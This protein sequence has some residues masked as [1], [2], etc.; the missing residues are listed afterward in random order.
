MYERKV[1]LKQ[2]L[3]ILYRHLDTPLSTRE[4]AAAFVRFYP[5]NRPGDRPGAE[6]YVELEIQEKVHAAHRAGM[7]EISRH[8]RTDV[9]SLTSA[10]V[11]FLCGDRD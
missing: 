7:V 10:G 1:L 8:E 3:Q 4:L 11:H 2:V 6:E 5:P 9:Y